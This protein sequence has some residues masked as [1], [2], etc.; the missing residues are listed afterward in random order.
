MRMHLGLMKFRKIVS[1]SRRYVHF[2]DNDFLMHFI[3]KVYAQILACAQITNSAW[4]NINIIWMK[5]YLE[6]CRHIFGYLT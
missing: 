6:F 1:Q 2:W 5:H 3:T 4:L